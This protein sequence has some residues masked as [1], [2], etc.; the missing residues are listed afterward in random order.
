MGGTTDFS[1]VGPAQ[2]VARPVL[3]YG[4]STVMVTTTT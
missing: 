1:H 3:V 4:N 2:L